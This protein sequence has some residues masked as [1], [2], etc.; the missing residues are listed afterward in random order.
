M[1]ASGAKSTTQAFVEIT[2]QHLV[3]AA[4]TSKAVL[5][6]DNAQSASKA[7]ASGDQ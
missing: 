3:K 5:F 6:G 1:L 7:A 2:R 4:R